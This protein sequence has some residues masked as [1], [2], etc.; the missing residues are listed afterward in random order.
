M[1][2]V[3]LAFRAKTGEVEE[4]NVGWGELGCERFGGNLGVRNVYTS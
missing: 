1:R 2:I 4:G 3:S